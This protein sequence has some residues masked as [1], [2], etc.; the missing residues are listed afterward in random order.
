MTVSLWDQ[1]TSLPL[2]DQLDLA[3]RIQATVPCVPDGLL[4]NDSQ[5]LSD[6]LSQ[7]RQEAHQSPELLVT[8]GTL[9][10][11]IRSELNL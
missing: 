11:S 1:I 4:P 10:E 9:V 5:A 8:A 3:E 2:S 7:A 6:A